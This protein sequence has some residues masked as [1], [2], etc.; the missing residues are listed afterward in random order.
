M[1]AINTFSG[2]K[3]LDKKGGGVKALTPALLPTI[4]TPF[5]LKRLETYGN[6]VLDFHVIM[7]LMPT[8][9]ALYFQRRLDKRA[10]TSE[11]KSERSVNLSAAQNAILLGMGIQ[12]KSVED[13]EVRHVKLREKFSD[14][15]YD[16]PSFRYPYRRSLLCSSKS[17]GKLP[18]GS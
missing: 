16:R 14:H 11:G 9:S 10:D 7:D 8:I 12:R 4:L 17:Y 6:N 13:I 3:N 5:D 18:S 2:V 15:D 1:E